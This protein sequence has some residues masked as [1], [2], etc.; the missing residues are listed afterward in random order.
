[1]K[2]GPLF[3][4]AGAALLAV[5]FVLFKPPAQVAAPQAIAVPAAPAV[6]ALPAEPKVF[7][8]MVKQ[9]KL[10]AGSGVLSAREGDEVVLRITSDRDDELHLH[11]YDL[12]LALKAGVPGELKFTANRSG[13]FDYELH[14]AHAE[15][16]A[17]EV[18]PK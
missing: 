15:L 6:A 18:Q 9:G 1:M 7:E 3:I 2:S 12:E 10:T 8:L 13:R 16:G 11:G 5:L 4:A 17:L 14:K